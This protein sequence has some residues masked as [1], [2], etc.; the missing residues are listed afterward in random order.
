MNILHLRLCSVYRLS[1]IKVESEFIS[2]TSCKVPVS[3]HSEDALFSG[4]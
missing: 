2:E 3:Q 4:I 1:T